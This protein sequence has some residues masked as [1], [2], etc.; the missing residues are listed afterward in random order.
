MK[1]KIIAILT[2]AICSMCAVPMSAMANDPAPKTMIAEYMA[3][4]NIAGIVDSHEI[5]GKDM[6][7]ILC[8]NNEDES[9]VRAYAVQIGIDENLLYFDHYTYPS[10]ICGD[11]TED[12]IIDGRDS[13]AVLT[14]YARSSVGAA[15]ITNEQLK[16]GDFNKD[17]I[18][19]ARDASMILSYYAYESAQADA[20]YIR[21]GSGNDEIKYPYMKLINSR[22]ELD[23]YINGK[24]NM[25][26][27][28]AETAQYSEEW[29][30]SHKLMM[31]IVQ[32]SSGSIGHK[33]MDVKKDHVDISRIEPQVGTC[34]MAEWH[35]LIE[36]DKN[37]EVCD[38]KDFKINFINENN[39]LWCI[40]VSSLEWNGITYIDAPEVDT[41][42]YT[43]NKYLGKV[44]EFKGIYKD[45]VNYRINPDDSV[46]TTKE[47]NRVLLIVKADADS[48]YG[49]VVA[50]TNNELN[51]SADYP[52]AIKV[53]GTV[54]WQ[55]NESFNGDLSKYTINKVTAYSENGTP[56]NDGES[57][58]DRECTTEYVILDK[59]TIAVQMKQGAGTVDGCLIF[60]AKDASNAVYTRLSVSYTDA[61]EK[62]GHPLR[63][64]T[65][66]DFLGY[67]AGIVYNDAE[68]ASC[69]EV[70]YVYTNGTVSVID[71]DRMN[72]S[73]STSGA[74]VYIV[75]PDGN[76]IRADKQ[77]NYL[78]RTFTDES[79]SVSNE[80]IRIGYYPTG[81]NGLA[82]VAEFDK[83]ADINDIMD[84]IIETE[85]TETKIAF[86]DIFKTLDA[87]DYHA[88]S[89]DGLPEYEL[90]AQ[91][92]TVYLVNFDGGWVWRRPSLIAEADN[93]APL[94]PEVIDAIR[95]YWDKLDIAP[96]IY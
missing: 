81:E 12:G 30:A 55:T 33:V 70:N 66:S 63:E 38:E 61:K 36:L 84:I 94:T 65:G 2:L 79:Y 90:T 1:K 23:S 60:K 44:S 68:E 43:K 39:Q 14:L 28:S 54:F 53:N 32:E 7:V 57:N 26:D 15:V 20:K 45:T 52:C 19:D 87:L 13:T 41:K 49:D 93:E 71:Q 78:G 74:E 69:F 8:E 88:I 46:Y 40:F 51:S 4:N 92:G 56:Q 42:A 73:L 85:I 58:F 77:Y 16:K 3:K 5:D 59:D 6:I 75:S 24:D 10:F 48:P 95:T 86:N 72:G 29:F 62:F 9:K 47:S 67:N 80:K 25:S 35:I 76:I 21:T 96:A 82:Y 64:G 37:A 27:F 18:L 50:M 31:V 34:D 11:F 22:E 83:T 91:D 17:N 89:C